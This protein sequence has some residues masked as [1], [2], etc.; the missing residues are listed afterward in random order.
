MNKRFFIP[1]T[2]KLVF[3][4]FTVFSSLIS[5]K[6]GKELSKNE[7][8]DKE[9][10]VNIDKPNFKCSILSYNLPVN[11]EGVLQCS[12]YT[13]F[14]STPNGFKAEALSFHKL[15]AMFKGVD[16][17]DVILNDD[18][19]YNNIYLYIDYQGVFNESNKSIVLDRVLGYFNSQIKSINIEDFVYELEV[20]NQDKIKN[21]EV[22]DNNSS[23]KI[24]SQTEISGN[25]VKLNNQS[26]KEL[27]S[28]LQRKF[29]ER[30]IYVGKSNKRYALEFDFKSENQKTLD[31]LYDKY[32]IKA[33]KVYKE[34][35]VYEIVDNA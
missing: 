19:K 26:L 6:K 2:V 34:F 17:I 16:E 3:L 21:H 25:R 20:K 24:I 9:L 31:L 1:K 13:T 29:S 18:K 10:V 5:C 28:E 4:I 23:S 30:V 32:G 27:S 11:D 22:R 7:V 33:N 12:K 8:Y 14:D 15:I 35:I